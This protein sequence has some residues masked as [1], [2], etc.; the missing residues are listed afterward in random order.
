MRGL[1]ALASALLLGLVAAGCAGEDRRAHPALSGSR[2]FEFASYSGCC[3][4]GASLRLIDPSTLQPRT[5]RGLRLGNYVSGWELSPDRRTAAFGLNSG[6]IVLVDLARPRVTGRIR[7][8]EPERE[9][10]IVSWRRRDLLVATTCSDTKY[11][12]RGSRL[13]LVDPERLRRRAELELPGPFETAFSPQSGRSVVLVTEHVG[14]IRPAQ[15]YVVEP[16]GLVRETTLDRIRVG[17]DE[18]RLGS[19]HRSAHLV[20][21]ADRAIVFGVGGLVAEVTLRSML[22]RYRRFSSLDPRPASARKVVVR[23]WFGTVDPSSGEAITATRLGRGRLLVRGTETALAPRGTRTSILPPRVLDTASWEVRDAR[24]DELGTR[25]GRVRIVARGSAHEENPRPPHALAGYGLDGELLWRL[26]FRAPY[27]WS[28]FAPFLYVGFENG[29][30]SRAYDARTGRLLRRIP[31][32]EALP[33]FR[34]T[35][36][37]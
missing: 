26:R 24:P 36:P 4:A 19:H 9:V 1:V 32:T 5:R 30:M 22:V 18:R 28:A 8:G 37:R 6:E 13:V 12:C 33:H 29:R 34:W 3:A 7:V 27:V 23:R 25:F 20:L 35:P 16:N 31:P 2:V 14:E 10:G 17:M 21:D 11:G 15:L